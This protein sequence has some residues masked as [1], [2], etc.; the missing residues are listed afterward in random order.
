MIKNLTRINKSLQ[1]QLIEL[2]QKLDVSMKTIQEASKHKDATI[3]GI[4]FDFKNLKRC[5]IF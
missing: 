5:R 1:L 2:N 3:Q 4:L